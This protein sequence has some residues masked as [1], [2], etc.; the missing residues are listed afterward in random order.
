MVGARRKEGSPSG[1]VIGMDADRGTQRPILF[2]HI[3]KTAG[4]SLRLFMVNRFPAGASILN[5]HMLEHRRKDPNQFQFVCGHVTYAF[6]DRFTTPP[7]LMTCLREPLERTIS[8]FFFLRAPQQDVELERYARTIGEKAAAKRRRTLDLTRRYELSDFVK[9]EPELAQELLGNMQTRFLLGLPDSKTLTPDR[10]DEHLAL[11]KERLESCDLAL[12]TERADES[13]EMTC[14]YFGWEV[15]GKLPHDNANLKRPVAEEVEPVTLDALRQLTRLDS[16][17]YRFGQELFQSRLDAMNRTPT[18]RGDRSP[19]DGTRFTMDQGI[20]GV[21]WFQRNEVN[22]TWFCWMGEEAYLDLACP[23]GD[24]VLKFEVAHAI[25]PEVL[26]GLRVSA[27]GMPLKVARTG[28]GM[29][30][31]FTAPLPL[32]VSRNDDR[33]VRLHFRAGQTFRPCDLNPASTN[34]RPVSVGVSRVEIV[35]A[36]A[37]RAA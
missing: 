10:H 19:P 26:D 1:E 6:R 12:L 33:R 18:C 21:G 34:R 15:Q 14:R 36:G 16:E 9:H 17:L 2:L 13:L 35:P 30:A 25:K 32:S 11:A 7:V 4:T 3:P 31:E 24:R 29:P 22:G 20:H 28:T 23:G 8:H 37:V 27:N 5:V